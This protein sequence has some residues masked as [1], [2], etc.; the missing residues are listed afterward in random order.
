MARIGNDAPVG[1]LLERKPPARSPKYL[2]AIRGLPC[3]ICRAPR[4]EAAHVSFGHHRGMGQKASDY[5]A[6]PLCHSHHM[7]QHN[8]GERDFW[9]SYGIDIEKVIRELVSAFPDT[10]VMHAVVLKHAA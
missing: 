3:L 5:R 4:S 1:S 2:A 7:E 9:H 10:Q 6:A 8:G